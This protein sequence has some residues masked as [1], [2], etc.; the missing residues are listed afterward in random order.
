MKKMFLKALIASSLFLSLGLF[1]FSNKIYADDASSAKG[2][3]NTSVAVKKISAKTNRKST[4]QNKPLFYF[5]K[6]DG[7]NSAKIIFSPNL[8]FS[9]MS[10]FDKECI[11]KFGFD[12]FAFVLTDVETKKSVKMNVTGTDYSNRPSQCMSQHILC[13]DWYYNDAENPCL[14]VDGSRDRGTISVPSTSNEGFELNPKHEY[15]LSIHNIC[16]ED[17]KIRLT[18]QKNLNFIAP[19]FETELKFNVLNKKVSSKR[20]RQNMLAHCTKSKCRPFIRGLFA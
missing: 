11:E 13:K 15:R 7:N 5:Y 6:K 3:N 8:L 1:N 18:K 14:D 4:L 19:A 17:Y 10:E 20:V 16:D 12:C 2:V 9:K